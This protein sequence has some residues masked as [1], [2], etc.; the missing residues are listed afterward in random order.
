MSNIL[1]MST[2]LAVVAGFAGVASADT[3]NPASDTATASVT[4]VAP[5]TVAKTADMNFGNI[6][7]GAST[8]DIVLSF[9]GTRS[10][11][12]PPGPQL[13]GG[14]GGGQ[15]AAFTVSTL[16]SFAYDLDIDLTSAPGFTLHT[17]TASGPLDDLNTSTSITIGASLTVPSNTAAGSNLNAGTVEL[18]ATYD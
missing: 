16:S 3:G 4:V 9:G 12:S 14:T 10:A 6:T 15:A 11:G 7:A 5:L 1:K 2:A 18:T 13:V 8:G 17:P